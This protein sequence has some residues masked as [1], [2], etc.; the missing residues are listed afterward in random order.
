[1]GPGVV[2]VGTRYSPPQY[3]P[4]PHTPG[5]PSPTMPVVLMTSVLPRGAAARK[6][7]VVGLISV[8]QLSLSTQISGSRGITEG[9]NLVRIGIPNDHKSIPGNE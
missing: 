5:T 2:L 3:P 7:S 6:N 9:Y 8:Q 1:M 4:D